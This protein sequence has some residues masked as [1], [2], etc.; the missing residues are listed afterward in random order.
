MMGSTIMTKEAAIKCD[1]A[2]IGCGLSGL[3]AAFFATE[4]GFSAVQAGV[5][6][7]MVFALVFFVGLGYVSF[8]SGVAAVEVLVGSLTDTLGW[9]RRRT[10]WILCGLLVIVGLPATISLDYL[11]RSD[12]IW[13]STMQPAGSVVAL[14][15][16]TWGLGRKKALTQFADDEG[17][18]G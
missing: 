5:S 3:A 9:P 16:L 13:G 6:G 10:A 11:F 14:A 18:Y 12:L 15:A 4:N 1:L 7:G 2:I 17:Q 8:L